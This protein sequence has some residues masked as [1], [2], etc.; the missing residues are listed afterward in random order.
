MQ[1]HTAAR[2]AVPILGLRPRLDW[3]SAG[4]T[5]Q[6]WEASPL[7]LVA[8]D[9]FSLDFASGTRSL[10]KTG[11]HKR[12]ER[13]PACSQY[14]GPPFC[15]EGASQSFAFSGGAGAPCLAQALPCSPE[16]RPPGAVQRPP[17][18][19]RGPQSTQATR[20]LSRSPASP[21]SP[22][23][24]LCRISRC[25]RGI[26]P[27]DSFKLLVINFFSQ[28]WHRFPLPSGSSRH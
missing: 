2:T 21:A 19:T 25:F 8:V 15:H 6:P 3:G 11:H 27:P 14:P 7:T 16:T 4:G 17:T 28:R 9:C 22:L 10:Y 20:L 24:Q 18:A 23:G 13:E 26:I 12:R 1:G 5:P